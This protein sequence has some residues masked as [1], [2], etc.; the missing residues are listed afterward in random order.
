MG[1]PYQKTVESGPEA[2]WCGAELEVVIANGL[3]LAV[4]TRKEEYIEEVTVA[5]EEMPG[6]YLSPQHKIKI[7]R[8]DH[9]KII[10]GP[11]A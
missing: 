5:T 1:V 6:Q 3:R 4:C 7:N 8:A 2:C 10:L 11:A 9:L